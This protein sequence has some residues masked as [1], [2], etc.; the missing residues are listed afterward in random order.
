MI[1]VE[2][3]AALGEIEGG[4][5]AS[6]Q[7]VAANSL[8]GR[9]RAGGLEPPDDALQALLADWSRLHTEELGRRRMDIAERGGGI[10]EMSAY[11]VA[12]W[13]AFSVVCRT[14]TAALIQQEPAA[15]TSVQRRKRREAAGQSEVKA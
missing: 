1:T 6:R 10:A 5:F 13:T 9:W 2:S 3:A 11:E 8:I 15:P 14:A 7:I 12:R 4:D